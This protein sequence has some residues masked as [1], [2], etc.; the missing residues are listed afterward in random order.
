MVKHDTTDNRVNIKHNILFNAGVFT[1]VDQ[2]CGSFV[3]EQ[4]TLYEL[5]IG[6]YRKCVCGFVGR[7]VSQ[8]KHVLQ[9]LLYIHL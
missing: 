3:C 9:Y 5:V 4:Y 2:E 6:L 8:L 1:D 7:T